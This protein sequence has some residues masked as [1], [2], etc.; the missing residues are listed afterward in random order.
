LEL[1]H[2][3]NIIRRRWWVA[4]LVFVLAAAYGVY[5]WKAGG[6]IYN[7]QARLVVRQILPAIETT[8]SAT[9]VYS[10]DGY[11]RDISSEYLVDDYDEIVKGRT[12][13][14]AVAETM[15]G[16]PSKYGSNPLN[17]DKVYGLIGASRIHRIMTLD[18]NSDDPAVSV[19]VANAA[20]ETLMN[21]GGSFFPG[22]VR[23]D[24]GFQTIDYPK[25]PSEAKSNASKKLTTGV[26]I[27]L[28]GLIIG[29]ALAFLLDYLD[30]RVRDVGD[31]QRVTDL[32]VIGRVPNRGTLP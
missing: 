27:V 29:L 13:A 17:G 8:I 24:V 6:N 32:P 18:I 25:D 19:N 9:N 11:Y 31:A 20:A 5:Q 4:A 22:G 26:I 23:D 28:L 7:A 1:R 15:K 2:F 14:D 21:K 30:D 3:W 10:Y 16:N 12:F